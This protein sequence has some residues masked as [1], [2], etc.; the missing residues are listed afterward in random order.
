[1]ASGG[2]AA[3]LPVL[4]FFEDIG[5]PILEGYGLT[6]ASSSAT[7]AT[8]DFR[9]RRLGCVGVPLP[10]VTVKIVDPDTFK[11]LATSVPALSA[12]AQEEG[13]ESAE[14]EVL[15]AGPIVMRGYHNNPVANERVFLTIDGQRFLRTGDLGRLVAGRRFLQITGRLREIFKLENGKFVAPGPLEDVYAAGPYVAQCLAVGINQPSTSLLIVPNYAA[16]VEY[17]RDQGKAELLG[18]I[19]PELVAVS[20]KGSASATLTLLAEYMRPIEPTA[21]PTVLS[22]E[23]AEAQQQQREQSAN[24]S[25]SN[26]SGSANPS[27]PTASS[28]G[29][30]ERAREIRE[31]FSKLFHHEDFIL[32]ITEEVSPSITLDNPNPGTNPTYSLPDRQQRRLGASLR[33]PHQLAAAAAPLHPGN[34]NHRTLASPS[35]MSL[36][37][38]NPRRTSS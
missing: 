1:M 24:P 21:L 37:L 5:I 35:T 6:E 30:S 26:P 33:P 18:L 19:P 3:S 34:P 28:S 32:L 17:A 38:T 12:P 16:I 20:A 11:E 25:P 10:G 22:V 15:L 8:I 2:A 31:R 29:E 23:C 13:E 36:T 9:H 4:Q 27:N 7:A 14:G